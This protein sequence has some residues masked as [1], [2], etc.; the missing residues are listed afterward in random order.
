MVSH[1]RK[2]ISTTRT[3]KSR[4]FVGCMC[5]VKTD[6]IEKQNRQC[7]ATRKDFLGD[8]G[9]S[10]DNW[11]DCANYLCSLFEGWVLPFSSEASARRLDDRGCFES[12]VGCEVPTSGAP[13]WKD[14]S[15]I[16]IAGC[17]QRVF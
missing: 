13:A 5:V 3:T 10:E 2:A 11:E 14:I 16:E 9:N 6:Q 8:M 7:K 12:S 17:N 15:N 4:A 1:D